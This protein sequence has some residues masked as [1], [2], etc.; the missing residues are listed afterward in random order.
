[1]SFA[2]VKN[3]NGY[4]FVDLFLE[5]KNI[6]DGTFRLSKESGTIDLIYTEK[7]EK[8]LF[9]TSILLVAKKLN[10]NHLRTSD[11]GFISFLQWKY[12]I[13]YHGLGSVPMTFHLAKID[14][15]QDDFKVNMD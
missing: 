4:Y 15:K 9:Y 13:Y 2:N 8:F 5:E 1:M 3:G 7:S 6:P 11:I 12:K 10:T 14:I